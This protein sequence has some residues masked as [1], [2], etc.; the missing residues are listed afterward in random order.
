[1][2]QK[3][4]GKKGVIVLL[5]ALIVAL[6]VSAICLAFSGPKEAFADEAAEIMSVAVSA[7][8]ADDGSTQGAA[9]PS[10]PGLV[11]WGVIVVVIGCLLVVAVVIFILWKRGVI[12]FLTGKAA[13]AMRTRASIDAT[14]ASVRAAK[15]M[16]EGRKTVEEAKRRERIEALRKKA[17]E[18]RDL[19]PEER[20]GR[21]EARAQEEAEKAEQSRIRSERMQ[22]RADRM[23][24]DSRQSDSGKGD[25]AEPEHGANAENDNPPTVE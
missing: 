6:C 9:E 12:Q 2:K 5:F 20:A 8:A 24:A 7:F 15:R 13:L 23:R 14:I 4:F 10:A 21:L 16:E 17:Q 18:M 3:I 19:S 11:W 22:A 25:G 1:M